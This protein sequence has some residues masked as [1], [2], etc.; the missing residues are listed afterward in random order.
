[1]IN[2]DFPDWYGD[3]LC[4]QVDSAIF[5][6]EQGGSTAAARAVCA[7]CPTNTQA[8]CLAFAIDNGEVEGIWAGTTP[9]DRRKIR[10]DLRKAS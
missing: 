8:Q 5:F 1:M 2:I 6:P 3:A 4:A 10:R 7:M 9:N